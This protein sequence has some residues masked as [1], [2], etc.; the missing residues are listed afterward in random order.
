ML[1]FH[2]NANIFNIF[3]N[4]YHFLVIALVHHPLSVSY[5]NMQVELQLSP[6]AIWRWRLSRT[7]HLDIKLLRGMIMKVDIDEIMVR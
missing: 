1:T 3:D 6:K 5:L 4:I 2:G 7:Q